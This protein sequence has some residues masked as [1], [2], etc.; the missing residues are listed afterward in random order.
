MI[1]IRLFSQRYILNTQKY[2]HMTQ[3]MTY[4]LVKFD[5]LLQELLMHQL[6]VSCPLSVER[7][8]LSQQGV[9]HCVCPTGKLEA[10]ALVQLAFDSEALKLSALANG[11]LE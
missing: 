2:A 7:V 5:L 11:S 6:N 3:K 4:L 9:G 8:D 10:F 1:L